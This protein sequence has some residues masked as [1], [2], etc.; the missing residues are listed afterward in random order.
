MSA[1][2]VPQL[3]NKGV[4]TQARPFFTQDEIKV[5][6]VSLDEFTSIGIKSSTFQIRELVRDYVLILSRTGMR[7]GREALG[8]KWKHIAQISLPDGRKGLSFSVDG[9]TGKRSLICQNDDGLVTACLMHIASRTEELAGLTLLQ[10]MQVDAFVFTYEGVKVKHGRIAA[11]FKECLV[12]NGLLTNQ[13]GEKRPLYS[14][15]HTY[16]TYQILSGVDMATLAVQMGTS[17]AMLEKHYS[18][19]KP[20]MKA[21]VL[22][23]TTGIPSRLETL[24]AEQS[25]MIQ[26]L[27]GKLSERVS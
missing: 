10:L 9:K 14:L 23:G 12:L 26:T 4:R 1:S 5:L 2:A 19:L 21:A 18:K 17:I 6:S 3:H 16:A 7:T 20:Y 22:H 15:R 11:N 8:L 13:H 25:A 27:L 24:V